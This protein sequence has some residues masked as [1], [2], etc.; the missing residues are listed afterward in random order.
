MEVVV[1]IRGE[2][3]VRA[4]SKVCPGARKLLRML[5]VKTVFCDGGDVE[6][7][8]AS[9]DDGGG[10]ECAQLCSAEMERAYGVVEA[11]MEKVCTI[12]DVGLGDVL[13]SHDGLTRMSLKGR[14]EF[15]CTYPHYNV[16][17]IQNRFDSD[18]DVFCNT[19]MQDM[20]Q[21]MWDVLMKGGQGHIFCSELQFGILYKKFRKV[22]E[23]VEETRDEEDAAAATWTV[24]VCEVE[25][26]AMKYTRDSGH[27]K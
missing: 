3:L 21:L 6:M 4:V 25:K 16:R 12:F 1:T 17:S 23:A 2:I 18:Y 15:F 19:A 13:D 9:K 10:A 26:D 8:D 11:G 5:H 20:D 22:T 14:V 7:A 27:Y 24:W